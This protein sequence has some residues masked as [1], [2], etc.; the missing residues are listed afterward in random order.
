MPETSRHKND[1]TTS[2]ATLSVRLLC[3]ILYLLVAHSSAFATPSDIGHLIRS[4]K[5][6]DTVLIP[7]QIEASLAELNTQPKEVNLQAILEP[8]AANREQVRA[9]L[10]L[11]SNPS[12]LTVSVRLLNGSF[13]D[14]KVAKDYQDRLANFAFTGYEREGYKFFQQVG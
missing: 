7:H 11:L 5:L 12:V 14:D 9:V 3:A 8:Y 10:N 4:K 1:H 13:F 2:V 6:E